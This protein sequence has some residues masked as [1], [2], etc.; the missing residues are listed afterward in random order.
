MF[1]R[2]LWPWMVAV[3]MLGCVI[4]RGAQAQVPEIGRFQELDYAPARVRAEA[5]RQYQSILDG[6]EQ[7]RALDTDPIALARITRIARGLI[8]VAQALRPDAAGWNWSVHSTTSNDYEA[9]CLEG[10]KLLV[11]SRFVDSLQLSDGEL[12]TL[13][14]HEIAHAIAEHYTETLSSVARLDGGDRPLPLQVA[15]QRLD[16]NLSV[17]LR[18]SSLIRMQEAEADQLG[19]ILAHRAGW[20]ASSM[21]GFYEK[22]ARTGDGGFSADSHPQAQSRIDMARAMAL[23]EA[24]GA[25]APAVAVSLRAR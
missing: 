5:A 20:R 8:L 1:E 16:S 21:L 22:L 10:G 11:N 6:L 15:I 24:R 18:L 19:M 3:V 2:R 23:L 13:L 17:Q 9:V 25:F 7:Q 12:A 4:G 14:G